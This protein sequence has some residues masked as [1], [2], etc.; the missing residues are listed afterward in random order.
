MNKITDDNQLSSVCNEMEH[1]VLSSEEEIKDC[2]T[3]D[4]DQS[5]S[6]D[7]DVEKDVPVPPTDN[8]DDLN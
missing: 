3:D 6:Q 5:G 7:T 2:T 1:P 8:V 4:T